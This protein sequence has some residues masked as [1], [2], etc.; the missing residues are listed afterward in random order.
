MLFAVDNVVICVR[1]AGCVGYE[2]RRCDVDGLAAFGAFSF[3]LFV[4]A[5]GFIDVDVCVAVRAVAVSFSH[6]GCSELS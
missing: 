5:D 1:T 3:V 4:F 6:D 2:T